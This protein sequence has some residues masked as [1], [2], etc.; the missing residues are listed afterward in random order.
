M[1]LAVTGI[2]DHEMIFILMF[3]ALWGAKHGAGTCKT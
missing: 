2:E 1:W 3:S